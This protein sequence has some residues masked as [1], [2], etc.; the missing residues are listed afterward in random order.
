MPGTRHP[1]SSALLQVVLALY[2]LLAG[3]C[4]REEP[5]G[6]GAS[7]P[8]PAEAAAPQPD[9]PEPGQP[10]TWLDLTDAERDL[11]GEPFRGDFPEIL[12]RRGLRVLVSYNH[13]QYFLDDPH[14]RGIVCEAMQAFEKHLNEKHAT[15]RHPLRVVLIPVT[16]DQLLPRLSAGYGD[17][18]A[19]ALTV[20]EARGEVVDFSLPTIDG[21]REIVVTG[22]AEAAP[23][24]SVE[25]LSG[26]E[27]WVRRSSSFYESLEA[28]N[29]RLQLEPNIHAGIKYLRWVADRYFADPGI[30]PRDRM[31][32][33][34]AAYNA[35]PRR[36]AQLREKA[37]Q[38]G[39]DANRWFRNV[40]EVAAREVGREPVQYVAN[41]YKYYLAYKSIAA[42]RAAVAEAAGGG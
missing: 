14:Q 19:G 33:S 30:D 22:P 17:V 31:L 16:R 7:A 34:F 39:L 36:V 35:G 3:G 1:S 8:A 18:A 11:L 25:D 27:V 26:R 15:G 2:L 23:L 28:L 24:A 38:A 4:T 10:E 13:T 9:E 41:I 42:R 40:E 6:P 21:L 29:R 32:F 5:Q 12:E 20:T 37:R